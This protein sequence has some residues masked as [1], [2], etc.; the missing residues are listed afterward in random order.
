MPDAPPVKSSALAE[1][2]DCVLAVMSALFSDAAAVLSQ[3]LLE[4]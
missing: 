1:H 4:L 2:L 3:C